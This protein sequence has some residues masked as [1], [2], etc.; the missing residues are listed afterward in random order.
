M[1]IHRPPNVYCINSCGIIE[2]QGLKFV[3]C[4][5]LKSLSHKENKNP[6]K[7][8]ITTS[9]ILNAFSTEIFFLIIYQS[10]FSK[11]PLKKLL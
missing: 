5:Y 2:D 4:G 11:K 7:L 3:V 1:D 10:F 8:F 9:L 6:Y